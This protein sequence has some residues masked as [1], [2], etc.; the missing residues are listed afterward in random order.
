MVARAR[1]GS[2]EATSPPAL[3][4][5]SGSGERT[6]S[7]AER[8]APGRRLR[9]VREA[10]DA[11]RP[12]PQLV[13]HARTGHT[14]PQEALVELIDA[15]LDATPAWGRAHAAAGWQALLDDMREH[16]ARR[17]SGDRADRQEQEYARFDD[18]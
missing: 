1:G 17:T 8:L 6:R 16:V 14:R 7:V 12:K 10:T 2:W 15:S 9:L 3:E 5:D 13:R 18:E 4:R 11:A